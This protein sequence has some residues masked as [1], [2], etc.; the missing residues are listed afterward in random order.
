MSRSSC[1]NKAEILSSDG[2]S[3]CLL[4]LVEYNVEVE[5]Y[6]CGAVDEAKVAMSGKLPGWS[7]R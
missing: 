2:T 1:L 6:E 5:L 7:P 4:K 3:I